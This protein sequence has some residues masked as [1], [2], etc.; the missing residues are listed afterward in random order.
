M[1]SDQLRVDLET[2]RAGGG[3]KP[4]IMRKEDDFAGV[5]GPEQCGREMNGIERLEQRRK[6][7][8]C[9]VQHDPVHRD[10]GHAV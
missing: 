3:S 10:Q 6:R 4:A 7:S 1:V 8:T 5:V 2:A 9:P